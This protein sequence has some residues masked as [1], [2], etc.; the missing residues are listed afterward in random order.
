MRKI[1]GRNVLKPLL[2][3]QPLAFGNKITFNLAFFIANPIQR[4]REMEIRK[5]IMTESSSEMMFNM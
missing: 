1:I 3:R 5:P 4:E 2:P